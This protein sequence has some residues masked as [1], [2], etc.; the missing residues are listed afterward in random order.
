MSYFELFLAVVFLATSRIFAT[1]RITERAS[2]VIINSE[3]AHNS[4][5]ALALLKYDH[6]RTEQCAALCSR[7]PNSLS[8][9]ICVHGCFLNQF[10][11]YNMGHHD[12]SRITSAQPLLRTLKFDHIFKNHNNAS[13][14]LFINSTLTPVKGFLSRQIRLNKRIFSAHFFYFTK[15][16][17][18]TKVS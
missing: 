10:D 8:F 11:L 18:L 2:R 17:C 13:G 6:R 7:T 14:F 4:K 3:L 9:N 12:S 15:N 5:L 1:L 16:R